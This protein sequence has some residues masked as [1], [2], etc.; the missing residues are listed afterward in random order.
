MSSGTCFHCGL[1]VTERDP[2]ALEIQGQRQVFCCPGCQAVCQAII[3]AGHEDYYRYREGPG[4]H[5]D[6]ELVPEILRQAEH[7]DREDIQCGFV[8]SGADWREASLIL[9]EIRCAACLWLNEQHLRA[10]EGVLDVEVD[11]TSHRARVRWDPQR[12]RLSIILKAIT[13]IG[14]VAHP[15]DTTHSEALN[16][17]R[18][19]RS[20]ERIVFAGA[21]GMPIMQFALTTYIM[22]QPDAQGHLPLWVV[23]G[24]W[25]SLLASG[26]ILAYSGQD[27]FAG[28]W[29]D[30]RRGRLGMD[31]PIV[32][33]LSVA[34]V[35]S[36]YATAIRSGEVY[37]DSIAMFVFLLLVARHAEL[38]GRLLAAA[39]LDRMAKVI[40][41]TA[42]RV[43][44]DAEREVA[45]V[46]L[47]PGDRVR[48][49]PG[50]TVPVDGRILEGV[51]SFDES[52]LSGEPLP[53]TQR[54]GDTVAGGAINGEQP[55]LVEV[56]RRADEST[57]SEIHRLVEHGLRVRPHYA[58]LA[59][60]AA[61]GF[62]AVILVIA[63]G[64]GLFW[65]WLDPSRAIHNLVAVL[66]VT[67][68]CALAL[69]APVTVTLGAARLADLGVLALR[70]SAVEPYASATVLACDK[71]GTLTLGEPRIAWS[72]TLGGLPERTL[73][74]VAAALEQASEHPFAKAFRSAWE[75]DPSPVTGLRNHPGEGVEG[76]VSGES[77]RL[78][79][80][81]F[82]LGGT[83]PDQGLAQ[84][85]Q[86]LLGE[87]YSVVLL[88][89]GQGP[90]ALFG[91]ADP[92]REGLS[93]FITGMREMGIGYIAV[94]S[95]DHPDSVARLSLRL[96]LDEFHGALSPAEKLDWIR[97]EQARGRRVIMLG[98]GLNDAPTLAAADASLSFGEAADAAKM[99]SDFLITAPT[100]AALPAARRL[101]RKTRRI[102]LQNLL[103][104]A[105]YNLLAVPLA[106]LGYIPPW[107]AAIG[108]SMS[109]ALV[110]GN[111]LRLRTKGSPGAAH[112][113]APPHKT[114]PA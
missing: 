90:Q 66:I 101:A 64:T 60:Q 16:A 40:P 29:R 87:G 14:Y 85:I 108:M 55:V 33:G 17:A 8:R 112:K 20:I 100:L 62:V 97:R 109:S 21:I 69:A 72:Q 58:E 79:R 65:W 52:L 6:T 25:T 50:E 42:R 83:V 7:Y 96:G 2:P 94:L 99:S 76:R 81:E 12:T 53:V 45:V 86:G 54:V 92:P 9:E 63:A 32:I 1:P 98:D 106:A 114:A 49:R 26:A 107:G 43:D 70:M 78:G 44:G 80:P 48:V 111:S 91:F 57:V 10:L 24:R 74:E 89:D 84:R 27:F 75:G 56:L 67:C 4:R 11:Y 110:V 93:A 5:A 41:A 77:W 73:L 19:R 18:K 46:E 38:R 39:S 82:A 13:S 95:G 104:A 68:P 37:N 28:A 47:H 102:V 3:G 31:V 23:I 30:L 51:S 88:A 35:G 113:P 105:A 103:W 22:G 59:E 36:L 34:W 71:T 61:A 15:Y